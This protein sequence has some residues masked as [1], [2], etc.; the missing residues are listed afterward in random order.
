MKFTKHWKKNSY[1]SFINAYQKI[2]AEILPN[3]FYETSITQLS[4]PNKALQEKKTTQQ[5][6]LLL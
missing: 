5:Y 3:L 1:Q 2:E 6:S 4:K